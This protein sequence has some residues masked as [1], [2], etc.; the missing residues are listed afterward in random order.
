MTDE[1]TSRP[2]WSPL[3]MLLASLLV[4]GSAAAVADPSSEA[5]K[6]PYTVDFRLVDCTFSSTGGNAFFSLNPGYQLQLE[7]EDEGEDVVAWITV[8]D[9][10][11]TVADFGLGDIETRVVEEREWVDGELAE[12]SRNL[13][14]L[15]QETSDIIYFGEDVDIFDDGQVSHEGQWRA[16][17]DGALPGLI[18]PGSFLLGS[19]YFQEVAPE[20]EALDRAENIAKGLSLDIAGFPTFHD[21]IE[22][23]ETSAADSSA[24]G[25][26]FYCAGVGNVIDETLELTAVIGDFE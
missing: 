19:R 2:S 24:K 10:T 25:T 21:C 20:A 12:I 16:G 7:G 6:R 1:R 18:M 13:F 23:F 3:T 9:E 15:C 4:L 8:L 11:E 5:R 22:I 17:E 14:A 26:K